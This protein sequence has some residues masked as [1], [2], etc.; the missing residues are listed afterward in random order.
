M[1]TLQIIPQIRNQHELTWYI[2]YYFFYEGIALLNNLMPSFLKSDKN[3]AIDA[4]SKKTSGPPLFSDIFQ[5][6]TIWDFFLEIASIAQFLS[7]IEKEGIKLFRRAIPFYPDPQKIGIHHIRGG[8]GASIFRLPLKNCSYENWRARPP[9][10]VVDTNFFGI[11][12]EGD[13]S[14]EQSDAFFFEIEEKL[15]DWRNFQKNFRPP[16]IFRYIPVFHHLR[17]FF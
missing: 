14:S 17:L 15:S 1:G 7:E 6:S 3:W 5:F 13:C 16:P 12:I 8:G 11:W 2:F 4:I 10:N 9:P